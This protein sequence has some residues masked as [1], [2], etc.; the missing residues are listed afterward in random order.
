M[1][2]VFDVGEIEATLTLDRAPFQASLAAAKSEG[3]DFEGQ[4]FT[5][6]LDA[7]KSPFEAALAEAIA[8]GEAFAARHFDATF[9]VGTEG[10]AAAA[11]QLA[12]LAATPTDATVSVGADTAPATAAMGAFVAKA[13]AATVTITPTLDTGPLDAQMVAAMLKLNTLGRGALDTLGTNMGIDPAQFKDKGSLISGLLAGGGAEALVPT[14][15]SDKGSSGGSGFLATLLGASVG[16]LFAG[17]R[18]GGGFLSSALWG[19]GSGIPF[20]GGLAGMGSLGAAAGLGPEHAIMTGVGLAGSAAGATIGGGLLALGAG[21]QMAVGG[22]SDAV[23]M[24]STIADTKTLAGDYTAL[25]QAVGVYG[26]TSTQAATATAQ[27]NYDIQ[28]LGNTAGVAAEGGL[29]QA[30]IAL[31]TM[32]DQVSSGARVQAVALLQQGVQAAAEYTPM[33]ATAAERNLSIINESIKPLFAWIEGPQGVGIFNDLENRFASQLPTAVHAGTQAFELFGNIVDIASS[34]TGGLVTALDNFFSKWNTNQ[35]LATIDTEIGKMIDDFRTWDSFVKIVIEDIYQLFH[36]DAGTGEAIIGTLTTMLDKLH[37]W[38]TS[39]QGQTD[40]HDIFETHK[41]EVLELLQL[42]PPL[43]EDFGRIELAIMPTLTTAFTDVLRVALPFLQALTSFQPSGM[44]IGVALIAAK[45]GLLSP[46][47]ASVRSGFGLMATSADT[48]ATGLGTAGTAAGA[49]ATKITATGAAAAT[50]AADIGT[51]GTAADATATKL[52]AAGASAAGLGT[53]IT[54]AGTAAD[55]AATDLGTAGTAADTTAVKMDAAGLST[56][57][58]ATKTDEAGASATRAGGLI[59]GLALGALGALAGATVANMAGVTGLG[60]QILTIGGAALGAIP[61]LVSLKNA[62]SGLSFS[63]V[64]QSMG[65]LVEGEAGLE[66]G[67]MAVIGPLGL[68]AA[69]A[70]ALVLVMEHVSSAAKAA[71]TSWAQDFASQIEQSGAPVSAQVSAIQGQLTSLEAVAK[72]LGEHTTITQ[73]LFDLDGVS[74]KLA[75]VNSEI[76]GLKKALNDLNTSTSASAAA[77]NALGSSA[78]NAANAMSNLQTALGN[79]TGN[80]LAAQ[81]ALLSSQGAIQSL[82]SDLQQMGSVGDALGS[83]SAADISANQQIIAVGQSINELATAAAQAN[84]PTATLQANLNNLAA[85]FNNTLA[86]AGVSQAAIQSFDLAVGLTPTQITTTVT[87]VGTEEASQQLNT[88]AT[89]G[90]AAGTPVVVPVTANTTTAT[91]TLNTLGQQ[92]TTLKGP[93]VT[94]I[95]ADAGNLTSTLA[96][97]QNNLHGI[98]DKPWNASLTADVTGLQSSVTN[99]Q[100][101][102]KQVTEG[103]SWVA[104]VGA[105]ISNVTTNANLAQFDLQSVANGTYKST[106]TADIQNVL[107]EV[108]AAQIA[109][110]GAAKP[111]LSTLTGD[112]SNLLQAIGN[113]EDNLHSLTDK[114]WT[115]TMTADATAIEGAITKAQK[116]LHNTSDPKWLSVIQGDITD[117]DKKI[118]TAQGELKNVTDPTYKAILQADIANAQSQ[119]NQLEQQLENVARNYVATITVNTVQTGSQSIPGHAAGTDYHPGG[120]AMVGEQGP[121]L[122]NLPRGAQVLSNPLTRKVMDVAKS[123]TYADGTTAFGPLNLALAV[124]AQASGPPIINIGGISVDARGSIDPAAVAQAATQA[125]NTAIPQLTRA[126]LT[127]V[128]TTQS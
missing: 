111:Y 106:M 40:L 101:T 39:T 7:D 126:I 12:G 53:K 78:N 27:L 52:D 57:G 9:G 13:D 92:V 91:T 24:S 110:Q 32:W 74:P 89:A 38:E 18:G 30:T 96:T 77:N 29:A 128:G 69:G 100:T 116:D 16:S 54:A 80:A 55:T 107:Q 62:V 114:P 11:A 8:E 82:A 99:A 42:L 56:G 70:T 81:S 123:A 47:L 125:V 51:A 73:W 75:K 46:L 117:L 33:V 41:Q 87:A 98:T 63:G 23:V 124:Q 60:S 127:G 43:L 65:L 119:A 50:T 49:A 103:S 72:N 15:A 17:G 79:T 36:N 113:A 115:T 34:Y 94:Q 66:L 122:V 5:A 76:S 22:G 21:G 120:L 118:S 19:G 97:M 20:L 83:G 93:F 25:N 86:S 59:N 26:A 71:G 95:A 102:L 44:A 85:S 35:G 2:D 108:A 58:L 90:K 67:S 14:A 109:L 84:Q 3:A 31:N 121:E 104:K 88:V 45:L 37:E 10:A 64:A 105:D 61:L 28:N 1:A 68:V 48:A 112:A 6:S 4:V